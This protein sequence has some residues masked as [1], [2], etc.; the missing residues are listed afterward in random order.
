VSHELRNPL[1]V[2]S[3]SIYIL[4]TLLKDAD[5]KVK[6]YLQMINEET[7]R[8][9]KIITD[10]LDFSK[11]RTPDARAFRIDEIIHDVLERTKPP[12]NIK[13]IKKMDKEMPMAYADPLQIS[14]VFANLVA[15]AVQAMTDGGKLVISA[16]S[17]G[18]KKKNFIRLEI[19][20]SGAGMTE[21]V[22]G[23][24]FEPLFTTKPR[25][26]GLG[27]ALSKS[28]IEANGGSIEA[29][30]QHGKGSR[31]TLKIPAFTEEEK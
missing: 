28:L 5:Q 13:V 6:E 16:T 27:L 2:I 20:D 15:N 24:I 8:S 21:E 4:T 31:F 30:S 1:G 10:M 9:E 17:E 25:G 12:E 3:N 7:R 29:E 23:K 22:L 19:K 11:V 26:I 14:Q 18:H